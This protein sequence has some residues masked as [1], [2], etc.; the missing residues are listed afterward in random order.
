MCLV[1]RD[2]GQSLLALVENSET[3]IEVKAANEHNLKN[4]D[5]RIPRDKFVVVTGPSGSGKSTLAFDIVHSEGQR[6]Y[7]E[8]LSAFACQFVGDFSRPDVQSV[9]GLPPTIAIEQRTTRG[10]VNSTVATM[11]EVY[12]FLRLLYARVGRQYCPGCGSHS[13]PF[14]F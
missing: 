11:T 9:T 8:S 13:S 7:L 6:R 12:H 3:H 1:L 5:V 10:A 14:G 2:D 4:I